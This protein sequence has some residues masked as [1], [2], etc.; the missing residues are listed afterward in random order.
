MPTLKEKVGYGFGDMSSSMF[1]KIFSY[2]LPFFYSNI[3][4]LSLAD[5][6]VLMLVTRVWDAVSDPMM[7]II[8]DRTDT[9][10]GKYRPYLL[11]IAAPF[12][13][14]GILLFTTPDMGVTG[15]LVWAYATYILMMTVYTAVNVPYG[16][17]LGVMT[18][19]SDTKTVFSSYRMF[20]AYGGSFIALGAWE[21]LCNWFRS[22]KCNTAESWQYAMMIIA[23]LCFLGFLLCF[24]TTREH[25]KNEAAKSIGKDVKS[26]VRNSP[27]WILNGAALLSN[28][29]NTVRGA[30]AAYFFKDYISEDAF[31]SFGIFNIVLYAGLFLMVGEV[32]NMIGVALAVPFSLKLGKKSAY[33]ISLVSLVMF[34]VLFFFV[35]NNGFGWWLMMAFQALISICTGIISPLVWSMYADVADYAEQKDGTASTGLIF[36]S[37]S[38]AQ[39]FGGAFAGWAV[40]SL[41]AYFGYDTAENAVQTPEALNG[42]KYL[43]SFIP[44]AIAVL[45]IL[46]LF[47]YP[48]DKMRMETISADLKARRKRVNREV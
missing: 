38:M 7:G 37:G 34:S 8:A 30:T 28:F 24:F 48:L 18:D 33:I 40:M 21:P 13:L 10:W 20:F 29:F 32:C 39:K 44:A 27:W 31:L 4:G 17:M 42:L 23:M 43:M 22:M 25:V 12:A 45:S 41:L 16:A 35:P 19:D 14:A 1:W 46:V 9:R 2:Y 26:L 36:S 6:G 5:A 3:F 47:I 11:W 15:K